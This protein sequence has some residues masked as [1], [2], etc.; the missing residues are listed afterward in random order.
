MCRQ[1]ISLITYDLLLNMVLDDEVIA[2]KPPKKWKEV[3]RLDE[4]RKAR[5]RRKRKRTTASSFQ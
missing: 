2:K 1:K 4:Q 5:I 3:A